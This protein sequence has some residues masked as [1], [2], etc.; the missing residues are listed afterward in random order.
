MSKKSGDWTDRWM[1]IIECRDCGGRWECNPSVS[2]ER[3]TG[4]NR[5]FV[6]GGHEV[7]PE[8]KNLKAANDGN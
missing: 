4:F 7:C 5:V 2:T 6:A 3:V 1:V 8:C